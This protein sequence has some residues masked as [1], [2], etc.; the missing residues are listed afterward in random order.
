VTEA[1][2]TEAA[3]AEIVA[4]VGQYG[5]AG[6]ETGGFLLV[7]R[8]NSEVTAAVALAGAAGITRRCDQFVISGTAVDLL[9]EWADGRGLRVVAQFHSHRTAAFLSP[10]DGRAGV[11]V[12]GFISAVIP[13]FRTPPASPDAWSWFVFTAGLWQPRSPLIT[14]AGDIETMTFDEDGIR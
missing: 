4:E 10:I 1:R 5:S 2:L 14:I 3:V 6:V 9:S 13:T 7:S 12:D 8:A 11:R